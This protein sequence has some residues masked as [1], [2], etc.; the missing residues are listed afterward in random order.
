[1]DLL[2]TV[3]T[4]QNSVHVTIRACNVVIRFLLKYHRYLMLKSRAVGN[5]EIGK[6]SMYDTSSYSHP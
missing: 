5:A 4:K 6:G 2:S 1:M 3:A